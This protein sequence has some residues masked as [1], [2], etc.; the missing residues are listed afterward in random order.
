MWWDLSSGGMDIASS[1]RALLP[2]SR[3]WSWQRVPCSLACSGALPAAVC[4][5][6]PRSQPAGA[7]GIAQHRNSFTSAWISTFQLPGWGIEHF[8]SQHIS[9]SFLNWGVSEPFQI[10]GKHLK[11]SRQKWSATRGDIRYPGSQG[12]WE[13]AVCTY[14]LSILH[15]LM[16]F[17]LTF[18]FFLRAHS[19]FSPTLQVTT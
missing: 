17:S 16:Y 10:Q 19:H 9:G 1:R 8:S 12:R 14:L 2:V 6:L 13:F 18:P 5:Q 7:G 15:V 11:C 3:C 4:C